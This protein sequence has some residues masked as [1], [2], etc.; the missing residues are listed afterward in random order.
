M[1][2]PELQNFKT[3]K[4]IKD[5]PTGP[6]YSAGH[7]VSINAGWRTFKPV[8][9]LDACTGCYQCYLLCPDGAISKT[10]ND[11]IKFDYDFCKGCGVCAHECR[12]EAIEMIKEES[13][14]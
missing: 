6:S 1:L 10:S 4:H 2:K 14:N 13:S 5:Y 3:P 7:L 11:K 12:F 9:S 8:V